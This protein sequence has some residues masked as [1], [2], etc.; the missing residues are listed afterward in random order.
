MGLGFVYAHAKATYKKAIVAETE[1]TPYLAGLPPTAGF[2]GK[3]YIFLALVESGKYGLAILGALY[4]AVSLYY[5]FRLVR[6]MFLSESNDPQVLAKSNG[7]RFALA[8]TGVAT[9]AMGILP[10]PFLR[11][12]AISLGR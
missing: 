7:V 10:E 8:I 4:I 11:M 6:S 5:Y 12:A 9:L 1:N 3:Y 2:I